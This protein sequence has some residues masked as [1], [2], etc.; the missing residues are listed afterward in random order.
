MMDVYRSSNSDKLDWHLVD[1][2]RD[3]LNLR[4]AQCGMDSRQR[5]EP[6]KTLNTGWARCPVLAIERMESC[7]KTT[8]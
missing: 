4:M 5:R 6:A 2:C 1:V 8:S 3:N 7:E